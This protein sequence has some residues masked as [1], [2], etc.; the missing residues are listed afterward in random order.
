M[1]DAALITLLEPLTAEAPFFKE[2]RQEF[3]PK[4][5]VDGRGLATIPVEGALARKPS[6]YELAYGRVEDTDSIRALVDDAA[7]DSNIR[8]II[9][10][11]DSPGGFFTGGLELANSVAAARTQKP[12]VAYVRGM[13]ASLGYMIASQADTIV[14]SPSA[15]VGSIGAIAA[16]AD[17][18][19]FWTKL[20]IKWDVFRSQ[21]ADLKAPGAYNT[22]LT[23]EQREDIQGGVDRVA[24][25][26]TKTVQRNRSKAQLSGLRGKMFMGD[27]AADLGL[28]D[29][30]GGEN[31]AQALASGFGLS[32]T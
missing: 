26:F 7:G 21:G 6:L 31:L 3:R 12:V 29:W 17:L 1:L 25:I 19:G 32:R 8:G 10:A 4:M 22:A 16:H 11:I 2:L 14:A 18:S 27:E 28:L 15:S 13:A 24:D 9:M 5:F 20:G 23:P 30:V